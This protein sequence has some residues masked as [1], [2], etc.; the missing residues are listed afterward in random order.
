MKLL[1]L[2][3]LLPLAV[4]A[5]S[6]P[7]A[8]NQVVEKHCMDCH[9]DETTKGGI[10]LFSLEWKL[11]DA[12]LA[13]TWVKVHDMLASGDMPPKKKSMRMPSKKPPKGKRMQ[14]PQPSSEDD[15]ESEQVDSES[16]KNES[17]GK[18]RV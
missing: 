17:K 9:D 15:L 5:A 7:P 10:D 1:A 3:V 4:G 14:K 13:H 11:D 6:I 16:Q 2:S 12:H 18:E 8:L